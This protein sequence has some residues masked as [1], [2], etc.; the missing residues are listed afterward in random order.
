MFTEFFV[1]CATVPIGV[2][3]LVQGAAVLQRY[4]LIASALQ[5]HITQMPTNA[6]TNNLLMLKNVLIMALLV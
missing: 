6:R 3:L 2:V 5:T 4:T 1:P